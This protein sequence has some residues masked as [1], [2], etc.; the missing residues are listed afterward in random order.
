MTLI[1][2]FLALRN[3]KQQSKRI[4]LK[5]LKEI[6]R[7]NVHEQAA[8]REFYIQSKDTL[9]M[10]M[11]DDTIIGLQNKGVIYQASNAGPVYVHGTFFSY[12]ITDFAREN[13]T[14]QMLEL[15]ENPSEEDKNRIF[16]ARPYWAKEQSRIEQRRNSS[17]F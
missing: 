16:N 7:L 12:A 17:W 6:A 13:L 15:P 11:L 4:E 9:E 5:I 1:N 10:P 3:K 8:L 2:Y 14:F